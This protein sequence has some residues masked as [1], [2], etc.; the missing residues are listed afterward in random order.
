M[1]HGS[2]PADHSAEP[3]GNRA[4]RTPLRRRTFLWAMTVFA[5][6]SAAGVLGV[7]VSLGED[8]SPV[9]DADPATASSFYAWFA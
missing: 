5:A 6:G 2:F 1:Y 3:N 9:D 4:G 7:G 8:P